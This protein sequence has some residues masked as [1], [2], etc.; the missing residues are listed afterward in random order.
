MMDPI[1]FGLENY[2]AVGRFRT[3]DTGGFAI[4]S[5]G[6][7]FD[8]RTFNGPVELAA[9]VSADPKFA[10]CTA[11]QVFTYAL[12]R[13]PVSADECTLKAMGSA[14]SSS[15]FRFPA[16]IVAIVSSDTFT[17]RHGESP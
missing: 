13:A 10:D 1:G 4:D 16:L 11:R 17:Q 12:G 8:G 7:L 6:T 5:S 3:T 15:G 14:F 9:T 2:D